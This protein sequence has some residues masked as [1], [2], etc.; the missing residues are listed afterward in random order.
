MRVVLGGTC[1]SE[2]WS[3]E[4]ND[5]QDNTSLS[6][7]LHHSSE[8]GHSRRPLNAISFASLQNPSSMRKSNVDWRSA[9]EKLWIFIFV[10]YLLGASGHKTEMR[11]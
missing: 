4:Q 5:I 11:P 6:K 9:M 3:V 10:R 2:S 1:N 8:A 7:L